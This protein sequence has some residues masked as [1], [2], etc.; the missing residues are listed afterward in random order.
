[1][2]QEEKEKLES[3]YFRCY[4]DFRKYKNK[5]DNDEISLSLSSPGGGVT[6]EFMIKWFD[7]GSHNGISP[8]IKCFNDSIH[9]MICFSDV[10]EAIHERFNGVNYT[11]DELMELLDELGFINGDS[12]EGDFMP[13]YMFENYQKGRLRKANLENILGAE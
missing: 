13:G 1:M 11:I 9:V 2:S 3:E 8:Q 5:G 10:I 4:N 7:L 12:Y 6:G